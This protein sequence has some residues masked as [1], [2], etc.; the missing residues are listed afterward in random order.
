MLAMLFSSLGKL[1]IMKC[2]APEEEECHDGGD[3]GEDKE[4]EEE[5]VGEGGSRSC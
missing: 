2:Q 5:P 4:E 3:L 1:Q